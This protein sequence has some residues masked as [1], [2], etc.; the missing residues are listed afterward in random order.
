MRDLFVRN[1][2][3][4]KEQKT[5]GSQRQTAATIKRIEQLKF[6]DNTSYVQRP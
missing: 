1:K 5:T 6:L 3:K 4:E 2:R